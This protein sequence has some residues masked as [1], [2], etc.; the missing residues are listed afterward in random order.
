MAEAASGGEAPEPRASIVDKLLRI[1]S[2]VRAGES[3]TVL[4]LTLNLF[5]P[6]VSYYILKVL[7][8]ALIEDAVTAS[9]ATGAQ[10]V[11]LMVVIPVYGWFASKVNRN[12]LILGV[13]LFFVA[14]LELFFLGQ[15]AGLPI[16]FAFFVW[17]GIF[18]LM[19]ISQ[20][21][22]FANDVYDKEAGDR[23]F[24]VI[25]VGQSAG[26]LVGAQVGGLKSL[27]VPVLF[28]ITAGL[29]LLHLVLYWWINKRPDV[30]RKGAASE[31]KLKGAGGFSLVARSPYLRLV[32]LLFLLL[33]LVNTT[34]EYILRD[35][36]LE[37]A[38]ETVETMA[39]SDP[40]IAEDE[41]RRDELV[42]SERKAFYG[43]F[44][45]LVNILTLLIQAF[46]VSRIVKFFGLRG[47]L[48][49][50]PI[51]ALAAYGS[52]ALG[53]GFMVLRWAK[54]AENSTDYS[55][56]N[57]GRALLWLPTNRDEK[58]KAKQ[59]IDTF[60]VRVG[61][62]ASAG[63]VFVGTETLALSRVGFAYANVVLIA[64]WLG[65]T[66]LVVREFQTLAAQQD[67]D[68]AAAAAKK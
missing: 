46:V 33:N 57:T 16:G 60:I 63:L 58:Y 51:I 38:A 25:A 43:D 48:F 53:A 21:W 26:A 42:T 9:Y 65:I 5:I 56:M 27:S 59:T 23:L 12:W 66:Y 6:L 1:F 18:S 24:P 11:L 36:V 13:V 22:G 30:S 55:V 4:L 7:R 47:V 39:A 28:Q 49:T 41:E 67:I 64:I 37:R 20:F 61:D 31:E 62:L 54:T 35:A 40:A 32:A 50:L 19:I 29:L 2:D 45:S 17:L 14:C 68:V 8:E 10:A 34:G 52:V 3:P 44:F 15:L